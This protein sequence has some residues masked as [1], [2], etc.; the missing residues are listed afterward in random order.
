VF[1]LS[2]NFP[3]ICITLRNNLLRFFPF[4][5][6][7]SLSGRSLCNGVTL[8]FVADHWLHKWARPI[9]TLI[10]FVPPIGVAFGT[11]FVCKHWIMAKKLSSQKRRLAS[12]HYWL[13]SRQ[14]LPLLVESIYCTNPQQQKGLGIMFLIP[15]T[16]VLFARRLERLTLTPHQFIYSFSPL[17]A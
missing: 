1:T 9:I 7:F 3:L 5:G 4:S 13:L 17:G 12:Q 15:A 8:A 16:L 10:A 14:A 11:R 2:T 6:E